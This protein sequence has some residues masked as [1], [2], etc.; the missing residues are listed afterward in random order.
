MNHIA[1]CKFP[2]T[3]LVLDDDRDFLESI[4]KVL[5]KK[6][7]TICVGDA[8]K[9]QEI[10]K[11][12]RGWSMALLQEGVSRLYSEENPSTFSVSMELNLLKDQIYN[13][14][15]FAN[16]VIVAI[17]YDMPEKNG[18]E[19]IRALED[20]QIKYIMLT[21]K[22]QQKT[23]IEG[24]NAREIHRYVSKG[25]PDYLELLIKFIDELQEEF[26]LD[27]SKFIL[28]SLKKTANPILENESFIKLFNQVVKENKIV[29][30]YLLDE[31]GSFV[32]LDATAKNQI[33]LIV[34]SEEDMRHFYEL[35]REDHDTPAYII[36]QLKERK[37]LTHFKSRKEETKTAKHWHFV[38]ARPLNGKKEYYYAITKNDEN[39]Q[40]DPSRIKSYAEFV[41][42]D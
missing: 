35:A 1:C 41:S 20:A 17:D 16:I 2:T 33:W 39:F 27:Y 37:L 29:E 24:F 23:V 9:A 11:K 18:L 34:K 13:L 10:L 32:M 15:R 4:C 12:N 28:D 38:E 25:D 26:F 3:I 7:H 21:G 22:A 30:Y 40:F 8:V 5:S 31:S 14:N 19:I 36:K 6:Y 42:R